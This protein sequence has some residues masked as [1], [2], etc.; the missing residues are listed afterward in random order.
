VVHAHVEGSANQGLLV[1]L[2][3][4]DPPEHCVVLNVRQHRPGCLVEWNIARAEKER[5][6]TKKQQ[7]PEPG[8]L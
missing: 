3:L 1:T 6:R 7:G 5:T 2:H 4:G 8:Y